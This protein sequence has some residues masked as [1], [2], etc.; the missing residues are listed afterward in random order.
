[1]SRSGAKEEIKGGILALVLSQPAGI[2]ELPL[3]LRQLKIQ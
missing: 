2:A 3:Q 1:M